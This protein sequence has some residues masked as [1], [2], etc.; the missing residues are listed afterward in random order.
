MARDSVGSFRQGE[1]MTTL[2]AIRL[3]VSHVIDLYAP[4]N[5]LQKDGIAPISLH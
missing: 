5:P 2:A 3:S 4:L 1:A